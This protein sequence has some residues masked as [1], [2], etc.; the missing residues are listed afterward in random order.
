MIIPQ[1]VLFV[2]GMGTVI[3]T[4]VTH[5]NLC[6]KKYLDMGGDVIKYCEV[7]SAGMSYEWTVKKEY[8]Y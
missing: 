6:P 3:S 4:A 2:V 8:D 1:V 7:T 5:P